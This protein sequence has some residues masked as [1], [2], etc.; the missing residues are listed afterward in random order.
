VTYTNADTVNL[1]AGDVTPH[2]TG[3]AAVGNVVV[4]NGTTLTPTVELW[5]LSGDGEI[6]ISI[7]PGTSLNNLAEPD[8]GAGPSAPCTIENTPIVRLQP[9]PAK[10]YV[11]DSAM[12][13][14]GVVGASNI[15]LFQW[16]ED[17]DHDGELD[18]G[19][20]LFDGGSILGANA[21]VLTIDP[22][23]LADEADYG[24]FVADNG[25]GGAETSDTPMVEVREPVSIDTGPGVGDYLHEG[26]SFQFE[27]TASG[28]YPP[29]S[30]TWFH[31]LDDNGIMDT[32]EELLND[33][34]I[35][36]ADSTLLTIDPLAEEHGGWY[37]CFVADSNTSTDTSPTTELTDMLTTPRN[38]T[39]VTDVE[40]SVTFRE[41]MVNFDDPGT[42]L[43]IVHNVPGDTVHASMT[44]TPIDAM[45]Y[46][47]VVLGVTGNGSFTLHIRT[48]A[49]G[50]DVET[51]LGSP[52]TWSDTL[53]VGIDH[54]APVIEGIIAE[55]P[56]QPN[57]PSNAD[58]ALFNVPFSED[59]VG[60]DGPEDI[61]IIHDHDDGR[62]SNHT[63]VV[64]EPIPGH[65]DE[66]TVSVLG[67]SGEGFFTVRFNANK[68]MR[69]KDGTPVEDP[70]G[71]EPDE[72]TESDP[73]DVDK[74]PPNVILGD[75]SS[76]VSAG[77]PV[78]FTVT[79]Q[80]RNIEPSTINLAG[81]I[82]VENTEGS[83]SGIPVV[84]GTGNQRT[85]TIGSITG[86]GTLVIRILPGTAE[87]LGTNSALAGNRELDLTV[88]SGVPM[89][90]WPMALALLAAG[91]CSALILAPKLRRRGEIR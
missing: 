72:G 11:G 53:T 17:A 80:D 63:D 30:Y 29:L 48:Q 83:A 8:L 40:I 20:E 58:D 60:F 67:L 41:A 51:A 33:G 91:L 45:H 35:S 26:G 16:F 68:G 7:D 3:T 57:A 64:I 65:A 32:G 1:T 61:E 28:G 5:A 34:P 89:A 14:V 59:I 52:L 86:V 84:T 6:S 78:H 19:E 2:T 73:H 43:I 55:N 85:V 13:E 75:L 87:D 4:T 70:A 79:Y 90:W 10:Y 47:I 50:G 62:D 71:N 88:I 9:S 77:A 18:G 82:E 81:L 56:T 69:G 76:D 46:T 49:E 15:Y 24:C 66:Y 23:A 22:L 74:R 27:V 36:G 42:D 38:P 21:D 39:N 12:L 44:L 31:D 37:G 54:I 25:T